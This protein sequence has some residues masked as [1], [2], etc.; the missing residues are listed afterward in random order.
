M[1][2]PDIDPTLLLI[3]Q[4]THLGELLD[5]ASLDLRE[6][7]RTGYTS[8]YESMLADELLNGFLAQ[9]GTPA[10]DNALD[11]LVCRQMERLVAANCLLDETNEHSYD[12]TAQMANLLLAAIRT[13]GRQRF[14]LR[15]LVLDEIS[16][17]AERL[18]QDG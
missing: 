11:A 9:W 3:A 2:T 1:T 18:T 5:R 4:E 17:A 13:Q 14:A 16:E 12:T 15:E 6:N 7:M 8:G 10:A